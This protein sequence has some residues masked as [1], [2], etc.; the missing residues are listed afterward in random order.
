ML[1]TAALA[2]DAVSVRA[3][4]AGAATAVEAAWGTLP[5]L[6]ESIQPPTFP[7]RDFS[8]I[9]FGAEDGGRVDCRAA[10]VAAIEKCHAEG[11]GRVVVPEGAWLVVGPLHLKSNVNLYLAKNA[12]L[13]F[14]AAPD[15]YLPNVLTRFE[16]VEVMNFSP[17]IYA[18]DQENIA[19][20]GPG[21]V[22]GQ[23]D[24]DNWWKWKATG[25]VDVQKL[26]TDAEKGVPVE[27]RVFGKGRQLRVNFIQPYRC[28]NVLIEGITINA[29]PMW[30]INPVL[31]ENVTVR[32]VKA[33]SHGPNNDGC[34]PESCKNVLIENC[35][36]DTGDD[37]IAIKSGRN[38]DGR[39]INRPSENIVVRGCR[40]KDGHGGVTLGSEMSGGIRNVFVE[41]CDMDSPQL[42]RAIRLK[43]NSSRGGY[44][45]NLYV[46]NIR[47][48]QVSDAVVHID[49]RYQKETGQHLPT[50]RNVFIDSITAKKSKRPLY[51]LGIK[52]RPIENVVISNSTFAGAAKASAIEDVAELVLQNVTQ[53]EK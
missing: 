50:V 25:G 24:F 35:L 28:K 2:G 36:F 34:N 38:A 29:S 18:L 3:S 21:A 45:E 51:L 13:K 19:I 15:D 30:L 22:N 33:D 32:G 44:L 31:C 52:E 26:N 37:C 8:I 39:R 49:L 20:T 27:Q 1:V 17:P 7:D 11:G 41:D 4:E 6:L 10:I 40:M 16:G 9:D 23:A 12:E 43:S 5:G 48:G 53:P 42:E 14:S 47:V 46:R